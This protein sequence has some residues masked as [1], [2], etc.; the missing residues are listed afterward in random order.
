MKQL[1]VKDGAVTL[2]EVPAPRVSP[3][4]VLVSVEHSCVSAGTEMAAVVVGPNADAVAEEAKRMLPNA[5][6]FVQ[7]ERRGT[8][9]ARHAALLCAIARAC[10]AR[11]DRH[12]CRA[13][14]AIAVGLT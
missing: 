2:A 1:L 8:A 14:R 10:I 13:R 9:H 6:T 12:L 11:A 5:Q 7:S 4:N 3:K